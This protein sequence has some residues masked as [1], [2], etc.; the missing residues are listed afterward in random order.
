MF[1]L[2]G[3]IV[4]ESFFDTLM[5][6]KI[7]ERLDTI[8]LAD[9]VYKR[10]EE[11]LNQECRK[12]DEHGFTEEE[13]HII[14]KVI[15]AYNSLNAHYIKLTYKQGYKDCAAFLKEIG[16]MEKVNVEAPCSKP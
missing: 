1:E 3:M 11:E 14:D 13:K 15:S 7:N 16:L 4:S 6:N 9:E 12:M 8:I 2:G 10:L 5:G